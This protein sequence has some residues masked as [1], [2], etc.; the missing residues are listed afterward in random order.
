MTQID[1]ASNALFCNVRRASSART[2]KTEKLRVHMPA[3][4]SCK[5]ATEAEGGHCR[6]KWRPQGTGEMQA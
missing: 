6:S 5:A 4:D 3:G 2:H 1:A